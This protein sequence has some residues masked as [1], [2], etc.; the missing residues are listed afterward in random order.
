VHRFRLPAD[1][2][3]RCL[4]ER[5]VDAVDISADALAVARK[6]R[7]RLRAAGP[8]HA[9]RVRPVHQLPLRKYDLIISNPPYVNSGSMSKLPQEY[10][11]E[12]QL[13]LAGGEDGMDLVRQIVAGAAERLTPDGVLIVEIGNER[14]FAEAA[15]PN[16]N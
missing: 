14:A 7:G 4:P 16:W 13:A 8:H 2:A 15:F 3:G 6:Q 10:L 9:D 5:A 11:R 12:P 1:H